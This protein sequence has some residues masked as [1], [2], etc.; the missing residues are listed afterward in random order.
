M[1]EKPTTKKPLEALLSLYSFVGIVQGA[2]CPMGKSLGNPE[3]LKTAKNAEEDLN[4]L[5]KEMVDMESRT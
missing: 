1:S 5:L 3:L 2:S 4:I